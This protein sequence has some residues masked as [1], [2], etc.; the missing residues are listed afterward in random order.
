MNKNKKDVGLTIKQIRKERGFSQQ[1][2]SKK[3]GFKDHTGL[4][5]IETG[6]NDV[7]SETT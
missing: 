6:L 2:L 3:M 4:T 5:K 7:N 1:E